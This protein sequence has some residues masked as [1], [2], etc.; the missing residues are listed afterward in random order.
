MAGRALLAATF[1]LSAA[2]CGETA[3][4]RRA[5]SVAA[6]KATEQQTLA[7]QLSAQKDSLMSVVLD[8]DRF[9]GQIDSS[10]SRVKGL[11]ARDRGKLET[12]GVLQDQLEARKDL[13]FKVNALVKR[14]QSTASQLAAAKRREA[15]LKAD[16][17]TLRDSLD[18]DARLIAEM[19][20]T[21]ERQ[22]GEITQLQ[23]TVSQLTEANTKLGEE[24]RVTQSAVARAY[25]VIGTEDQLVK[26]GIIVREGGMNLLVARPGRTVHAARQL[27]PALFT[28]IDAREISRIT[29][30]DSTKRYR[31]VS[32]HSLDAAEVRDRK[33]TSFKG[34]L[35]ITDAPRFWAASKFLIVVEG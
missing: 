9:L 2:A 20:Q 3:E 33:N 11:P 30:P 19:G 29:V 13:L 35:H 10:I 22:L 14:A 25:Y 4:H 5:D 24:L 16:N 28:E 32:R 12:E 7:T 23:T 1:V 34:D 18:K 27:D 17:A 15:G 21:I 8:A 31:I 26:K 6:V